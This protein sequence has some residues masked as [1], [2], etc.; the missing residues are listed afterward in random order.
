MSDT[1]GRQ[2]SSCSSHPTQQIEINPS[3]KARSICVCKEI[4]MPVVANKLKGLAL[5]GAAAVLGTTLFAQPLPRQDNTQQPPADN[6]KVNKRDRDKAS[7][8]ADQ[9]KM[10]ATDRDLAKR[11]R[12]AIMDDT[13]LSC[14]AHNIKVM[15]C[16][17]KV[18]LKGLVRSPV[19]K[20]AT[21][22]T[23]T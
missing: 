23:A 1:L 11:T 5:V 22:A 7:P 13:S 12:A 16:G 10:S 3:P 18:T 2:C 17:G 9:Q 4:L 14:Y 21:E 6:S 8:T 15:A 20:S 19:E